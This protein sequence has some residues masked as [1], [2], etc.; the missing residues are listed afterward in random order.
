MTSRLLI[1]AGNVISKSC[2]VRKTGV[3]WA[4]KRAIKKERE[5]GGG[6]GEGGEKWERAW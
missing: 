5:G 3:G 4:E 2:D 6:G 1:L